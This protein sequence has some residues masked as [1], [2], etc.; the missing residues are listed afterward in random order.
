MRDKLLQRR[1][2]SH[3]SHSTWIIT[4]IKKHFI[5]LFSSVHA[6]SHRV[7]QT[8]LPNYTLPSLVVFVLRLSALKGNTVFPSRSP[9]QSRLLI[10][11]LKKQSIIFLI[12]KKKLY[13]NK[14]VK[15]VVVCKTKN[16]RQRHGYLI[17]F[18][19]EIYNCHRY[20][21]LCKVSNNT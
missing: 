4:E 10:Y 3:D 2:A 9:R 1:T 19:L 8:S 18:T 6:V 15:T 20:K 17:I 5:K 11:L 7:F 21:W 14:R 13:N 12:L 16:Y